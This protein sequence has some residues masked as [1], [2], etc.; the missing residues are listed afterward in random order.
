M[1]IKKK[2]EINFRK[3]V[4]KYAAERNIEIIPEIEMPGHSEEVL[5]AYP[6]IE[7]LDNDQLRAKTDEIKAYQEKSGEQFA[8]L[9]KKSPG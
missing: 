9:S 2:E 7:K 4:I 8:E 3:K 6:E 5:A 1:A